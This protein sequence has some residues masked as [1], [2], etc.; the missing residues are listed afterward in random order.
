MGQSRGPAF[1][2][3]ALQDWPQIDLALEGPIRAQ[4]LGR[5]RIEDL[6]ERGLY[7]ETYALMLISGDASPLFDKA[8]ARLLAPRH[9]VHGL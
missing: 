2:L 6:V 7:R 8:R 5:Q 9:H 1:C 4:N 3:K